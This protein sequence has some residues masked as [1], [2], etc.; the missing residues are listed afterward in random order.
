MFKFFIKII[1]F[2]LPL[3]LLFIFPA[4]VYIKS[5]EFT[6]IENV[7]KAQ[8]VDGSVIFGRA[9]SYGDATYKISLVSETKPKI[10]VLGTSRVLQFRSIFFRDPDGFKNAG[11]FVENVDDYAT[12]I[13][14]LPTD[15][16]P[17]VIIVGLDPWLF[18]ENQEQKARPPEETATLVFKNFFAYGWRDVYKDYFSS[19]FS[20]KNLRDS[21]QNANKIGLSSRVNGNGFLYDGS[22]FN[23]KEMNDENRLVTLLEDIN[24]YMGSFVEKREN[25]EY[26]TTIPEYTVVS[27]DNFLDL[28]KR[29]NIHVVGFVI[30]FPRS[31]FQ[32][33]T[34]TND[35]Y[36]KAVHDFPLTL[37]NEFN[38]YGFN[39][40]DYSNSGNNLINDNEY[41]D[42]VH[43]TDKGDLRILID[44]AEKDA[45]LSKYVDINYL[46]ILINQNRSDFIVTKPY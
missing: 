20:L 38:K 21:S 7:I 36:T 28:C 32:E 12:F 40:F 42:S 1:T 31:I 33:F 27:L 14:E 5:G 13:R 3:G 41:V 34:K 16:A 8:K 2:L 6:S 18:S 35:K 29:K 15:F 11:R 25:I 39:V 17:E 44:M 30:P 23:Y 45:E 4:F 9:Y 43:P 26:S 46:K 24:S 10:I 19:K 22:L 37:K